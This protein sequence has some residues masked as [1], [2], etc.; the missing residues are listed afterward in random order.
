M[1]YFFSPWRIVVECASS[2]PCGIVAGD[3]DAETFVIEAAR[4]LVD[5]LVNPN[6][7]AAARADAAVS[8]VGGLAGVGAVAARAYDGRLWRGPAEGVNLVGSMSAGAGEAIVMF[9]VENGQ[10]FAPI[11]MSWRVLRSA[12]GWRLIDIEYQG[13]WLSGRPGPAQAR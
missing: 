10:A 13:V 3:P 8:A 6:L 5:V 11:Q 4:G 1:A 7:T 9:R 12:S 2:T